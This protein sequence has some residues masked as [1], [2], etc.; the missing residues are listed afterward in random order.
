VEIIG[1]SG[2]AGTG[3]DFVARNI[4]RPLG[5]QNVAYAWP[6]KLAAMQN[7]FTYEEAFITK[8]PRVRQWLQEH[9][10]KM[11]DTVSPTYWVDQLEQLI[12]VLNREGGIEKFVITDVRFYNEFTHVHQL[13]GKLVRLEHGDRPYPLQGTAAAEHVSECDLDKLNTNMWDAVI[14]NS[15]DMTAEYIEL[16]LGIAGVIP[17]K[18]MP[19]P[20][21]RFI[22]AALRVQEQTS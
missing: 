10:T 16:L 8:P 5:Y 11:R 2:K 12:T 4:L 6:L 9:G 19:A 3:K 15:T 22:D 20:V 21:G 7:G 14:V 13:G 1:L 17:R 18:R